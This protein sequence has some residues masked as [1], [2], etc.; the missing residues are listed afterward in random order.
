MRIHHVGYAVKCMEASRKI[1]AEL[2]YVEESEVISDPVRKVEILFLAKD[3]YRI[4]LIAPSDESC[5]V[6]NLLTKVGDTPYHF[7]YEVSD[8]PG[9]ME[10]MAS[11]KFVVADPP[12]PAIAMDGRQV[13]FLYK[14]GVGLVELVESEFAQ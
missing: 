4:E 10:K 13:A 6:Q 11:Q 8:L 12:S 2:G 3:G 5:A 7:C 14:A 1:F 9:Q